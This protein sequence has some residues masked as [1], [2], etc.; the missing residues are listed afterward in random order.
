M[1][2]R[3][4]YLIERLRNRQITMEEATELFSVQQG[5]LRLAQARAASASPPTVGAAPSGARTPGGGIVPVTVDSES[6]A[7]GL[8]LLGAGAGLL[9]AVLKRSQQAEPPARSVPR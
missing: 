4:V 6:V 3:Y 1:N 8:L 5:M 2:P 7:Y 9:A